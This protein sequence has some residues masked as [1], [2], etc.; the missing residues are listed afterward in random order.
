[1]TTGASTPVQSARR[2]RLGVS[3][4][5]AFIAAAAAAAAAAVAT[6]SAVSAVEYGPFI[7]SRLARP[8]SGFLVA[9]SLMSSRRGVGYAYNTFSNAT[10]IQQLRVLDS[11]SML[12][13]PLVRCR[14]R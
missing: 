10:C 12:S 14:Y 9:S 11:D 5:G 4:R 13:D 1:M 2:N 6:A 3:S 8:L 7:P